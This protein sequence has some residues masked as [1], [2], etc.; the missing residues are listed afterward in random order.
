[1]A[2]R[3]RIAARLA[4]R[5]LR[6]TVLSSVLIGV[7]IMLPIAGMTAYAIIGTS[8]AAT[9]QERV[10]VELG[11][12]EAWIAVRGLPGDGFWQAPDDPEWNGYSSS[13][14]G[15]PEGVPIEDP[16][17]LL[18]AGTETIRIVATDVRVQTP[19]GVTGLPAW[20][21]DVWDPR[22]E[23]RYE[24]VDGRIPS[25][26]RELM[27]TPAALDRLG[28]GIGEDVV[29]TDSGTSY[30]VVGTLAAAELG[31]RSPALF[32]S[33]DAPLSGDTRWYLPERALSWPEIEALNAEGV[34]AFSRPVVLDPPTTRNT[35]IPG[36]YDRYSGA[37][38]TVIM[39]LAAGGLFAAYVVVM[40]AG[41][42]FAVA[43]RRQQR[44]LA[45]A[46]SVGASA[47]DLRRVILLQGTSLGLAG[48][49]V[50]V[51]LG[52]GAAALTMTLV[53]DGSATQFWGFHVPWLVL[54]A[55]LVFSTLVG[56]AS[57][58]MPA[59][60]VARSDTLSALRGARRPQTPRASR[61]IWGSLLL[62]LG[63]ALTIGSA[64]GVLAINI[65]TMSIPGDSPLRV[66]APVGIV[67]GPIVFQ[68]GILLSG[69][70]LLWLTSKALSR[71]GIAARLAARDAAANAS[72]TVPAF[73]A[74]AATVFIAV[75]AIGQ[76]AMQN[77]MTARQWTYQAP[78]GDLAIDLYATDLT[79][80]LDPDQA[81]DAAEAG[82]ELAAIAGAE[83][84]AVITRQ[85]DLWSY[86]TLDA[87][88]ADL[89]RVIAV[90]P[91]EHLQD[92]ES[93]PSFNGNGQDPSNP[94]AVISTD[95][96]DTALGV[97]LTASQRADY[98]SGAAIVTDPRFVT[99]GRVSFGAWTAREAYEAKMPDNIWTP[100]RDLPD[101]ADPIWEKDLDAI[102]VDLPRQP[103]VVAV[104]PK[105][106]TE[107][108]IIAQPT[109]VI[110]SFEAPTTSE[111][112][113][114][115]QAQTSA[116]SGTEWT[117]A[118][119]FEDGPPE[120]AFWMIPI[121][122]AVGVLVLG[123]SG[124][125]LSLARFERRPDDATISA[126]GGTGGLRRRVGF[127][128][129]L[130]IAGFGTIAGAAAG[131]LPPIGFAIQS[132]GALDI[133]D[134]PWLVLAGLAVVLPLA[135]AFVS[136]AVPPRRAD[137][138]RRTAIA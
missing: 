134:M 66:I 131:V 47:S 83:Q 41:A 138:T 116:V 4:N 69:R 118:A 102:A 9:P 91:D 111:V 125:A 124:V 79:Q 36:S 59:R 90:L 130:I 8:T 57:A 28:V 15:A 109:R 11:G 29:L 67:I 35:D 133:G 105:T 115:V 78:V 106:A 137:L 62:L 46:A 60:T 72:R 81:G 71:C 3:W 26:S 13:A 128:Q 108:G 64:F 89:T 135:I 1:M 114:R 93:E 18:P 16:T 126:V 107:L 40:L 30:T 61:P 52:I 21:G 75:F 25:S 95:E 136:W 123:A 56:T 74:I 12:T 122:T 43:A 68:L 112:R 70:W 127:W 97:Q 55:I 51:A 87:I 120:D 132:W 129:G 86:S 80:A 27:T 42:A 2:A 20:S 19:D 101:R 100:W 110:A 44:T 32:L 48:G 58:A 85:R 10:T 24:L 34:V 113:D 98:R 76:I 38:M 84:T 104:S 22:F 88:P 49:L 7:L 5:Q 14:I 92:P 31:D 63:I 73:A 37:T 65:N 77:A 45:V 53:S 119:Y 103:V 117:V 121:L 50:G 54:A 23:G 99:D 17:A 96:I 39:V 94:I 82:L 6:R 33:D